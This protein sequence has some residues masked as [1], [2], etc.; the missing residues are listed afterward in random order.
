MDM[1]PEQDADLKRLDNLASWLDDRFRVPGTDMRFGL[2]ALAGLVP[3]AGDVSS[4]V[5]SGILFHTMWR[6]GAG[7]WLMLRMMGNLVLDALVGTI[8]LAGDL[9]DFGFKANRRN[10]DLLKAYYA[11][12]N[13]KP[14]ARMSLLVIGLIFLAMFIAMLWVL[15]S[16]SAYLLTNLWEL[17]HAS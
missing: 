12:G 14:S 17:L 9:F 10:V 3:Y 4:F 11:D 1:T 15:W 13:P 6:R 16:V 8:P 5:V 2:D 7:V